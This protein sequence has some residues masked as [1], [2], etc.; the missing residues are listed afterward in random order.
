MPKKVGTPRKSEIVFIAPTGEEINSRK[1]LEH[2]LKAHPGN[3]AIS[4]FDWGTGE[5]PRRS[6]R[7][8]EK[9]KSTPPAESESPKKRSRKLSGSKK[10]NKE[11]EPAS[12]EG[13]AKSAADE[14]K[15]AEDTEMKD[16]KVTKE[17]DGDSK[18][19]RDVSGEKVPQTEENRKPDVD[20][21]VTDPNETDVNETKSDTEQNKNRKVEGENVTADKP[22]GEEASV[23]ESGE[24]VAGE[25]SDAVV[26]EKAQGEAPIESEKENGVVENKQDK[27][28]NVVPE[29]NGGAEKENP[30]ALPASS[31]EERNSKKEIPV[32]D[33]KNTTQ[34]EEQ[35]K[36]MD[37]ELVDNGKVIYNCA[38]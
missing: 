12:G 2:Y 1:Q 35:V 18:R 25:A 21:E 17:E 7:I 27:S 14:P 11:T 19:G 23:P 6:A 29:A 9:V 15:A 3:P 36:K 20:T 26:T 30:N 4:E 10:D 28:D 37:A 8:S 5:T 24:K 13:K 32:T 31:V 33:G 22:P 34:A 16:V 38:Q